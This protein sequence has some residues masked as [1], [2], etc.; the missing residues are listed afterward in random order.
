MGPAKAAAFDADGKPTK[1]AEGFARGQGVAVERPADRRHRQ[2]RVP[3]RRARRSAAAR[4]LSCCARSCRALITGIPFQ[5]VDALGGPRGALR[6]ADPLDRRP[7]TAA[8]WSRSTFGEHRRS[9]NTS[10]GH[11]FMAPQ[12]FAVARLST[13]GCDECR[14]PLRHGR[15]GRAQGD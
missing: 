4:P 1:A 3:L 13:T 14:E 9:G 6:P 10:R 5:E 8:R 7:V 15:S 2:G 12:P 11:R